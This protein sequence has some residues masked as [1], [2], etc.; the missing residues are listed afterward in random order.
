MSW[1]KA[2]PAPIVLKDKRK[3]TTLQEAGQFILRLSAS[4]QAHPT[5]VYASELLVIAAQS[6]KAG[7]IK[8][9]GLQ[10]HRAFKANG[11]IGRTSH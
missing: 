7:D 3:I 11:F 9:A 10:V 1:Q 2:L 4:I 8:D 5:V 6:G